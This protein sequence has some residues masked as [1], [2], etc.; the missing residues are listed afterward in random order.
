MTSM[1]RFEIMKMKGDLQLQYM[2]GGIEQS[3][4][5]CQS[6]SR[7]DVDF[8]SC[9]DFCSCSPVGEDDRFLNVK[10]FMKKHNINNK[11]FLKLA[12]T[13]MRGGFPFYD[14]P[15]TLIPE[16]KEVLQPYGV[17]ASSHNSRFSFSFKKS[18]Y[19]RLNDFVEANADVI[20]NTTYNQFLNDY[21]LTPT[22]FMILTNTKLNRGYAYLGYDHDASPMFEDLDWLLC[23][24]EFYP[25]KRRGVLLKSIFR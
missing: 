17:M 10:N 22:D 5:F 14:D 4:V 21:S 9:P 15:G 1:F 23:E 24:N 12:L 6:S 16:L 3:V 20:G 18:T 11:T 13:Y 8:W 25:F 2:L 19:E 7:D